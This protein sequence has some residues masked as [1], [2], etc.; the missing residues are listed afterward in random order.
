[1]S[2]MPMLTLVAHA[3][4]AT[5]QPSSKMKT[6][7]RTAFTTPTMSVVATVTR[8]R[9]MPLKKP[10]MAQSATPSGAPSMRG[11]QYSRAFCSTSASSP[12]GLSRRAP[13]KANAAKTG[14]VPAAPQRPTHVA[15]PA[16]HLRRLPSYW[17]TNVCTASPTP[18]SRH[19]KKK[20]SQ[21]IAAMPAIAVVEM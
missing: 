16:R 2:P 6:W 8:G 10:R 3:A 21:K 5:P 11:R 17:A 15:C 1:M 18:P 12:N 19:T 13:A 14:S 20:T 9:E 4:P 7:F